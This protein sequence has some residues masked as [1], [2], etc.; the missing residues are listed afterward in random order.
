MNIK[1]RIRI[2]LTVISPKL[3][4]KIA[5]FFS[6]K[7]I[8]NLRK[9]NTLNEKILWLKLNTYYN[10]ETITNCI[11]KYKIRE[12][13]I[14]KNRSDLLPKLYGVYDNVNEIDWNKLPN[15]FVVKCNHGSGYNIIVPNATEFDRDDAIEKINKWMKEDYWKLGA[16]VQYKFINKKIIIEEYLG[17]VK[18]YKYYCFNGVPKIMYIS[19]NKWIGNFC[20]KDRYL[21]YYDMDFNHIECKFKNHENSDIPLEKPKNFDKMIEISKELS[22]EF[23]F[24]RVDL[25]DVDGKIYI[26]ELTFVPTNGFMHIEPENLLLE[27][28]KWLVL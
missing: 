11:D 14:N 12:Y 4:T 28:G 27:W 10:N 2:I 9:P 8:L 5:Y 18:T 16:E 15:S 3:E 6:F 7:K 25:Y 17:D 22:A 26:S 20:D 23:P 24:V 21:D 13:L 1:N 19:S